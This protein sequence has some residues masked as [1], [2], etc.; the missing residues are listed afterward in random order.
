MAHDGGP[1]NE[2]IPLLTLLAIFFK[3]GLAFGGGLGVLAVLEDEFVTRR[4]V[5]TR[6]Q[7]L[8]TYGLGRLVPSGT[9]TAV[10]IEYGYRLGGVPGAVLAPLAM[11][12]PAFVL[13]V[14]L[15]MAYVRVHNSTALA[16]LSVTVLPAALAFIVGAAL[17]FAE[18]LER[19]AV[20]V[21]IAIGGFVG[22]LAGV[23]PA[24]LL[25]AGGALGAVLF[26]N[27]D[28]QR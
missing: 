6:E 9:V 13:T 12:L 21:L 28:D 15:T 8:T 27:G 16:L 3:A 19:R 11:F 24:I 1:E 5:V 4:R 22:V 18:T 7:F 25:L 14:G 26:R 17:R 23:N 10:A 2:S 20:P